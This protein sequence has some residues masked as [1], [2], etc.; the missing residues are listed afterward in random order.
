MY[1]WLILQGKGGEETLFHATGTDM[2]NKQAKTEVCSAII[3]PCNA[4]LTRF[5]HGPP[6]LMEAQ[7][8]S[9]LCGLKLPFPF[10][11]AAF[12]PLVGVDSPSS[13]MLNLS[14][15]I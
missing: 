14:T 7:G 11:A 5:N 6:G 15:R 13:A 9:C 2:N 10:R 4:R 3:T 12:L 8:I 1:A